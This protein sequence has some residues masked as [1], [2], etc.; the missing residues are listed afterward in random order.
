MGP[1]RTSRRLLLAVVTVVA[2]LLGAAG[3]RAAAP[4]SIKVDG[5]HFVNGDGTTIRLLGVDRTS[6]E[7]GCV[8]GYGYDDGHFDDADAAAVASWHANAVRIPLNEDCWLG[9]NGQPNNSQNPLPNPQLTQAGYQQEIENYVA[10]LNAHGIYAILDLHWTA[11]GSQVALEQQPM[12]DADHSVAFWTSVASAFRNDPAVVFDLF[13]EP[14]DPT[15]PKSGSDQHPADAV[16]WSCWDS[17]GCSTQGYDQ[18]GT[19]TSTYPVAGLQQLL[20]AVRASGATQPVM[21]GGLDYA[22]DLSGWLAHEPA[23]PLHQ[24]AASFHNYMGKT[25]DDVSCWNSVI[26]PVAAAVPVVTG[27]FA[28]DDFDE[29][30]CHEG[31]STFDDDYMN[32]ADANGVSYL[33]WAWIVLSPQEQDGDGCS[34]YFLIDD[35]D[36]HPPSSPNGVAVHDHLAALFAAGDGLAGGSGPIGGTGGPTTTP[37]GGT[38]TPP[39]PTGTPPGATTTPTG[40]TT[41]TGSGASSGAGVSGLRR[42]ATRLAANGRTVR[43]TLT[44]AAPAN[45]TVTAVTA[46]RYRSRGSRRRVTLGTAS[47]QLKAGRATAVVLHLDRAA[48]RLLGAHPRPHGAGH[49]HAA[50]RPARVHRDSPHGPLRQALSGGPPAARRIR[51]RRRPRRA[52]RAGRRRS[53]AGARCRP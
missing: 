38:T 15:D 32:W 50:R 16:S 23:D 44:S 37:P 8:D 12:P 2:A 9:I 47:F 33:A 1:G 24:E 53:S 29:A 51:P 5:N 11:P 34:A 13:N 49:G 20:D 41:G 18:N 6:S 17:G 7:Y 31:S 21:L 27:E 39:G 42:F 48:R 26:A 19:P 43:F 10:A 52:S 40:G 45:G 46:A 30:Q 4:L 25:C 28:E 3:A 36:T 14:F 22:N 35:Y